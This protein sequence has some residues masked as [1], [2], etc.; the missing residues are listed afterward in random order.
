MFGFSTMGIVLLFYVIASFLVSIVVLTICMIAGK[1]EYRNKQAFQLHSL[2]KEISAPATHRNPNLSVDQ[3][4]THRN[5]ASGQAET[6]RPQIKSEQVEPEQ[7]ELDKSD[8]FVP[9]TNSDK[10]TTL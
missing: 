4:A 8:D 2:T 10:T 7:V 6:E 9:E 1:S 5:L 3:Q